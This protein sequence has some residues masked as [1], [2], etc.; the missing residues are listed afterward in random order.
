MTHFYNLGITVSAQKKIMLQLDEI[1]VCHLLINL[2]PQIEQRY[3]K[4]LF[5]LG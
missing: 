3:G 2:E 1:L 4:L 5:C